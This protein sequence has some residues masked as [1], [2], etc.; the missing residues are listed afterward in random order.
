[1]GLLDSLFGGGKRRAAVASALRAAAS[2]DLTAALGCLANLPAADRADALCEVADH[3]CR[4]EDAASARSMVARALE[5]VPEHRGALERL[6][7]LESESRNLDAAIAAGARLVRA[8]PKRL[9]PVCTLADLLLAVNRPADALAAIEE[10]PH[11]G[12][13]TVVLKRGECLLALDRDEEALEIL[14]AVRDHFYG[15]L[16]AGLLSREDWHHVQDLH[17]EASRLADSAQA[18]LHGRESVVV[19]SAMQGKLDGRAGVN[20]R[21]LGQALMA[22]APRLATQ[23]ELAS[24]QATETRANRMLKDDPKSAH[25]RVLKGS[26]LL[27]QGKVARAHEHFEEATTIDGK[28]FAA[29][30]G[31]GA[32]LDHER[33]DLLT[34]AGRLPVSTEPAGLEKVVPDLPALTPLEKRVV[35]ATSRPLRS[36]FPD[37][38]RAGA[39][40]R[41]LPIDVRATD[42]PELA[43]IADLRSDDHRS[44]QAIGGLAVPLLAVSRIDELLDVVSDNG[45][46]FAHELAHLA[47]FHMPESSRL[48]VEAIYEKAAEIG[49]V[50]EGY[51]LKNPDEFFAVSY[52]DWLRVDL[53]LPLRREPDEAGIFDSVSRVFEQIAEG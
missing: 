51:A 38:A 16:K 46:V 7:A 42:L 22:A 53:S 28:C 47:F 45:L 10:S 1:M 30:L 18:A 14:S 27:R 35:V 20:Y 29:F 32:V 52:T 36:C 31:L 41:I 43:R 19:D 49:W 11:S 34:A 48:A 25:G 44:Y 13:A 3:C 33:F 15:A 8:A 5:T 37:L 26:A 21:L 40:I 23:L 4:E 12:E 6:L 39:Q 50:A 24:P 2:K 17:G 9:E